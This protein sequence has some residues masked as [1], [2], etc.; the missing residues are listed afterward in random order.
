MTV[1]TVIEAIRD[2]ISEEMSSN[3]R[4]IVLG[5]DV[6][7]RGGVFLATQGFEEQF[8]SDRIIDTPLAEES[9]AG[10]GV[11]LAFKG[12][13]PIIEIQFS[14]FWWYACNQIVG[15]ASRVFYGSNGKV[16][17]PMVVRIPYGGGIR[18]GLFHSQSIEG[19]LF[20]TPGLKV[21]APSNP[22]DAK[23]LLKSAIRDNNPVIC[24]EH[25][26]TYRAVRGEVPDGDYL[27]PIG[28]ADIKRPGSDVT[29][30]SYGLVLHYV[31]EAAAVL[32]KEGTSVEVV[33]LRSLLPL[34]RGTI[35]DSAKKTGKVLI[36]HED[37]ITGGVGSEISAII[38]EN[39]FEFLDA[40]IRR[41]GGP[42]I[43]AVPFAPTLEEAYM[44]N[45]GKI[46]AALRELVAY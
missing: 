13:R 44:L 25:K 20:N 5:E 12:L 39:A 7:A 10:I 22:Y 21:V 43:P 31:M 19:Y 2:A 11:G 1:K 8:G 26:R 42:D 14:D 35:V 36:V 37:N 33:D 6:G 40:P 17:V 30:I 15:E 32:E 18:G 45:P 41:I 23:G 28:A 24:L 29:V 9:I 38:S 4:V 27:I 34:D 46:L 3:S 16:S